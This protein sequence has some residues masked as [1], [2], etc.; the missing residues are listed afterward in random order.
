MDLTVTK[1]TTSRSNRATVSPLPSTTDGVTFIEVGGG[2][3]LATHQAGSGSA[4]LLLHGFPGSAQ[5]W[6][7]VMARLATD[8]HVIAPDLLGFGG[9]S[10]PRRAADLWVDRQAA[11][12]EEMLAHLGIR[13]LAVVG[14]DFGGPVAITLLARRPDLVSHLVLSATNAFPDTTIPLPVRAVIWPVVGPLA[15][16]VLFS[17]FG[18]ARMLKSA[19]GRPS[20]DLEPATYLGDDAQIRSIGEIF[21]WSLRKLSD[22][23]GAMP[24]ILGSVRVPSLVVWGTRDPFF[25]LAVG[26]RTTAAIPGGRLEILQGA[27]HFLPEERPEEFA[28]LV[29]NLIDGRG[30]RTARQHDFPEVA[31]L[32]D[33]KAAATWV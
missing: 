12:V 32:H 19:V 3:S 20:V 31:H 6:R 28:G 29:A 22:L 15:G 5:G 9:S 17:R 11:A 25:P 21:T 33:S 30:D 8:H 14:H 4:V 7:A 10:K 2:Q 16:R 18:L 26:R 13:R 27:G 1:P 24:A 23:Y